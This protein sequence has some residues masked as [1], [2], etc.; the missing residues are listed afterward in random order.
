MNILNCGSLNVDHVYRIPCIVQPGQTLTTRSY[1][2]F[3]GGKGANQSV[4]LTRA[5]ARVIHGGVVGQ[6]GE[7]LRDKLAAEG[8]NVQH[9]LVSDQPTGQ[10]IIQ[11]DD[12]GENAIFLYPGT[13][14]QITP[15]LVEALLADTQAGDVLLLQNEINEVA[16][17]IEQG[18]ARGLRVCLNPAPMTE[19]VKGYPL[20]KL[21]ML[22]VNQTEALALVGQEPP[23]P[24]Q[25]N[26][27]EA[28][29]HASAPWTEARIDA[30]LNALQAL[31]P[32][33]R[34]VLTLGSQGAVWQDPTQRLVMPATPAS[35]VDTTAAGDTF[36]GYLLAGEQAGM[37]VPTRLQQACRAA[38]RCVEKMGAMDSIPYRNDL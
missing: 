16:R 11:V 20:T 26:R 10:A 30:L 38:A 1:Q 7:F 6:G 34:I 33:A 5:G 2:V 14:H 8:V 12:A 21:D 31:A 27:N 9:V 18:H 4:A 13:N 17:M 23:A 28:Q 3:A 19:A 29:S 25:T 24:L 22:I 32:A 35:V 36:I 37:D 15:A